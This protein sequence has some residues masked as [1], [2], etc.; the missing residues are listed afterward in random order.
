MKEKTHLLAEEGGAWRVSKGLWSQFYISPGQRSLETPSSAWFNH[1]LLSRP[2]S[3]C[4]LPHRERA[5]IGRVRASGSSAFQPLERGGRR[6]HSRVL[7]RRHS[8]RLALSGAVLRLCLPDPFSPCGKTQKMRFL[9][10]VKG[11]QT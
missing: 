8:S 7:G 5:F 1:Q 2:R 9:S 11:F 3:I 10:F 6:G 4:S